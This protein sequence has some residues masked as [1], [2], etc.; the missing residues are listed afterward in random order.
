M[1]KEN[2]RY[3]LKELTQGLDVTIK[4]DPDTYISGVCTIDSSSAGCITFL[5]NPLYK[6]Y[7]PD[8]KAAA[9]ILQPNEAE[10]C[11]VNALVCRDPYYVY[12][13]I[14]A[15]FEKR[16][17][18]AQGIHPSVVVGKNCQV[19]PSAT[20]AAHCV[21]GNNVQIGAG[22]T[23]SPGCVIGDSCQIDTDSY[24][25]AN[26]T[27]YSQV[28]IGQRVLIGSGTVI[29]SDG[30]GFAKNSGVWHKVPQ[31]GGVI[32]QDDVEIGA[33]CA[34]DRGAIND[35]FIGKGVKLDNLIQ[36]AHNVQIGEHTAI[37]A[38]VGISGSTI[39]GKNCLV[40]GQTGFAGHLKI[41]DNVVITGGTEVSK[42]IR[43]PGVYS[44]GIGGLVSN[45]EWRKNSARV[46]RLD[47]L[48]ER[49]TK[50]EHLLA[51]LVERKVT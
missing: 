9:V 33:N 49:V 10:I 2:N 40:G 41:A 32:I 42:S 18:L 5:M 17:E 27:L 24:L 1:L 36:V 6:K 48:I 39:I 38:C 28:K 12:A 31:L 26:V 46:Q 37:A 19:H 47:K 35:T 23:L 8:T 3:T 22:V 11:P 7:L 51:E 34:I 30:L 45:L 20:I 44:S 4:G 43:E 25:Y 16:P 14:A 29:G 13:K 21:I 50:L 15:F